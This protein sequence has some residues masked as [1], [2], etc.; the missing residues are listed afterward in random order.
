MPYSSGYPSYSASM[1]SGNYG[2][3]T[4][5]SSG[6]Y[7][8]NATSSDLNY[9]PP[10]AGMLRIRAPDVRARITVN[11]RPIS[12]IGDIRYYV[13]P[14]LQEGQPYRYTVRA[15][16]ER[17]GQITSIE[18]EVYAVRGQT[19]EVDLTAPAAR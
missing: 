13:T 18:R 1:S 10:D 4:T 2:S 15:V 11:D 7:R 14:L 6:S 12:N 17:D 5:S 3:N 19:T 9:T 16:W 8:S